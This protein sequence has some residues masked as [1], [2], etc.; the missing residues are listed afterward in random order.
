MEIT[1]YGAFYS[2]SVSVSVCI[3]VFRYLSFEGEG[4][5]RGEVFEI[6]VYRIGLILLTLMISS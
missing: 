6:R 4:F 1:D 2:V 5:S 3:C